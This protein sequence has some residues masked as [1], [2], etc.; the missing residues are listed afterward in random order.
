L[1]ALKEL[2]TFFTENTLN[3]RRNLR[4]KIERRSLT[5]NEEFLAAFKQVKGSL[6][7][8][9]QDVLAMNTAVQSMTNRLQATKAQTSQLLEQTTKLQN[10]R[11][12]S[13][14]DA[15][16]EAIQKNLLLV[17]V[18]HL[19]SETYCSALFPVKRYPCNKK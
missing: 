7:D 6:D 10:E 8:V 17:R 18:I 11:F 19:K 12:R 1:E 2:S 13:Y 3:S 4:S 14:V 16:N 5:I 9:Y 15:N